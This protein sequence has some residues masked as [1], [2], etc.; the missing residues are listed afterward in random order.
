M[1][2]QKRLA[3]SVLKCSPHRIRFDTSLLTEIKEA[4]TKADIRQL[5][6]KDTIK[7]LPARSTS[8]ARARKIEAQKRKGRRRGVGGR[9][10]ASGAR[11]PKKQAWM[12]TARKQRTLLKTLREKDLI[13][14]KNYQSLRLK[15][16]G[17]FFRSVRHLKLYVNEQVIKK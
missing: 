7:A 5:I 10:G 1:K 4:I 3:A 16:R 2:L 9:K 13:S 8:R 17:G 14:A 12:T 6:K 15:I 11:T